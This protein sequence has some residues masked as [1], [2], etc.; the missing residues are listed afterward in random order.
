MRLLKTH[1]HT[2]ERQGNEA[3]KVRQKIERKEGL[4][5]RGRNSSS[6]KVIVMLPATWVGRESV[7]GK[8]KYEH[9]KHDGPVPK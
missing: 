2:S 5:V 3:G 8:A 4:A 1:S 7:H 9:K 6:T